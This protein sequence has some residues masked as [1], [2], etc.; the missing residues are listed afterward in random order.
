[1]IW[2][3]EICYLEHAFISGGWTYELK[4]PPFMNA[5]CLC[6]SSVNVKFRSGSVVQT[7]VLL[8]VV[9]V[10]SVFFF[11]FRKQPFVFQLEV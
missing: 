2:K 3:Y 10:G 11:F 1:M 9:I 5:L 4:V 6:R 7:V 8:A